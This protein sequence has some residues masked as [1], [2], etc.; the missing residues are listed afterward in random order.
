M[1][2]PQIPVLPTA[3]GTPAEVDA[4]ATRILTSSE[5]EMARHLAT[6]MAASQAEQQLADA[7]L[8][9]VHVRGAI[10][11]QPTPISRAPSSRPRPM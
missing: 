2:N 8:G 6:Q 3:Q 9:Q 7:G 10:P 5:E 1:S 4:E 11:N